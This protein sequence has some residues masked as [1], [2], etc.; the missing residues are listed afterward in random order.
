MINSL[1]CDGLFEVN[2]WFVEVMNK[3]FFKM[4]VVLDVQYWQLIF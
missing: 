1:I 2:I 4:Q 3:S